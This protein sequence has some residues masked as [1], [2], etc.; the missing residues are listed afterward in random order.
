M[1]TK[2]YVRAFYKT[3]AYV[4]ELLDRQEEQQRALVKVV[5]VLK[6]PTQGDLHNPRQ[7]DVPFFHQRKALAEFEKTWV[8]LSSLQDFDGEILPYKLSLQRALEKEINTLEELDNDWAKACLEKL[9]ECENEYD[10]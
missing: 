4:A 7:V 6:H 2:Q 10:F 5:A 1:N 8:P 9:I 3:G